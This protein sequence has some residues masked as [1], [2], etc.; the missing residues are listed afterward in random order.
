VTTVSNS[1][2]KLYR[3]ELSRKP[4]AALT[5]GWL[6]L[7]YGWKPLLSDLYGSCEWL[8]NKLERSPRFKESSSAE[9]GH[10]VG[11]TILGTPFG[12]VSSQIS[13]HIV[14][15]VLYFSQEGQHDLSELGLIN[16]VSIAWELLPW[17][18]VLDWILP[19]GNYLNNLDA[20]YGLVFVKGCRTEFWRGSATFKEFGISQ[21]TPTTEFLRSSTVTED[22]HRVYV[23]REKLFSFPSAPLP[24]FRSPFATSRDSSDVASRVATSMALLSQAFGRR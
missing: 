23:R 15:Y 17:S 19:I 10:N 4:T 2:G 9:I 20:T 7:Q 18:F 14:R 3:K 12:S 6:E 8:A 16:P 5:N 24:S 22:W 21:S 11:A 1:R 13:Y